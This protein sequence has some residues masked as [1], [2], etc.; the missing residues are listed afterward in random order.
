MAIGKFGA[1][2]PQLA[3]GAWVHDSAQVIGDVVLGEESSIWPNV[4]ARGDVNFIKIGKQTS[5][6][7]G[8]VLHVTHKRESDPD[9]A[10]LVIGDRVT[11]GHNVILHGCTIGNECLIG[12][13]TIILDRAVV[14][15]RVMIGA[16]SL[17]PPGKKLRS[18]YLYLG[19]PVREI[20][21]LTEEELASFNYS[22]NNYV[23]LM[24]RYQEA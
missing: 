11:V 5:I 23:L 13:G 20:R 21:P 7:D 4:A 19:S 18:G 2:T 8:S 10:P 17:V 15:D 24:K 3:E 9:G 16:G 6:Q 22:A 1:A 12:M 14:Q